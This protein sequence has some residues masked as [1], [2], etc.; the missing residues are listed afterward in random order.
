MNLILARR[1]GLYRKAI[2]VK[3]ALLNKSPF[4]EGACVKLWSTNITQDSE[5]SSEENYAY[6]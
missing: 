4:I 1:R 6:C 2:V 3:Q 5:K